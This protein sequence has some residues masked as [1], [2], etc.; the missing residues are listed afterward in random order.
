ML[1]CL[2]TGGGGIP[3]SQIRRGVPLPRSRWGYWY[4]LSR[5][6]WG[7]RGVPPFQIWT[8]RGIG[9]AGYPLSLVLDWG[10][11]VRGQ[12]AGGIPPSQV[13]IGGVG[14][15]PGQVQ[16]EGQ[17][18]YPLPSPDGYLPPPVSRMGT[19]PPPLM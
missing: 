8:R 15:S 1:L 14:G 11:Q 10:K 7:C 9:G 5:C 4:P 12:G 3:P 13:R 6:G 19:P 2:L 18:R 16:D 17:G